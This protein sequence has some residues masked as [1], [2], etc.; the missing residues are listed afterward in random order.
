MRSLLSHMEGPPSNTACVP[1]NTFPPDSPCPGHVQCPFQCQ[2]WKDSRSETFKGSPC[3]G[4]S[5][6]WAVFFLPP[7]DPGLCFASPSWL[8]VPPSFLYMVWGRGLSSFPCFSRVNDI[9]RRDAPLQG[10]L[11]GLKGIGFL[12]GSPNTTGCLCS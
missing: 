12:C 3:V 10:P 6:S 2:S 4:P 5:W 8:I 1:P 7:P 9:C 11:P